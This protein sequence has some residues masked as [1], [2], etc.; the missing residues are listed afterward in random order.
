MVS[1]ADGR[2]YIFRVNDM[3]KYLEFVFGKPD[4]SVRSPKESDFSG[5]KGIIVVKGRGWG[6]ASGHITLWDGSRCSDSCHL[7]YDPDNGPFIP[8]VASIWILK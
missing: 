3:M 1:G 6:N 7:M 5:L 8:E 4:K 2:Q